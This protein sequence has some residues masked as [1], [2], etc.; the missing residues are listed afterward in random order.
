MTVRNWLKLWISR[1]SAR[2][3]RSSS[4]VKDRAAAT[5]GA[6]WIMMCITCN[7]INPV[8]NVTCNFVNSISWI[9]LAAMASASLATY[10][11][12]RLKS[13]LAQCPGIQLRLVVA[14]RDVTWPFLSTIKDCLI[15]PWL[16]KHVLHIVWASYI[17]CTY[18]TGCFFYWSALRND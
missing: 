5:Q 14:S 18:S 10:L 3:W 7:N 6:S 4:R 17:F 9:V 12:P 1:R 15:T 11:C 16:P 8:Q 13:T 2:W